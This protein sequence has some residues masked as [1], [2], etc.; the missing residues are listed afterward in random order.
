ME[1]R[2]YIFDTTLRD[3]EQ[4]LKVCLD[5]DA[6]LR[7]ARALERLGVDYIEAGFPVSSPGD[8]RAVEAIA[9]EIRGSRICALARA[10]QADI[11]AAGESLA[12]AEASR[13]HTFIAT[14]PIHREKKLRKDLKETLAMAV[15]AVRYARQ[16]TDDVEFSCEDAGRTPID[17]LCQFVEQTIAAGASVINIPD[18]VGY[19]LP[20]EFGAII[21]SL[22]NRVPNIDQAILSVH[23][24]ND[25]GL[26]VANTIS[27]IQNGARQ[28]EVTVNGIGERAGN[29]ALEELACI[30]STRA[31]LLPVS[32]G[33]KLKEIYH[34]SKVVRQTCN[35]PVQA[36]KAIV[37]DNAFSHSS[38]IH[39]DGLLK[40][41]Q[42]YEIISPES[43]GIPTHRLHLTARSGRHV[44]KHR[45]E[46]LGYREGSDYQLDE[47]YQRFLGL[48]DRKGAVYDYDLEA[49]V[50]APKSMT[51]VWYELEHLN[52]I[53]SS[54]GIASATVQLSHKNE[55]AIAAAVG[56]GPI[57]AVFR[58]IDQISGLQVRIKDYRISAEGEGRDALGSVHFVGSCQ[59]RNFYG[60]AA[61][62]DIVEAS[63]Q[64]YL[65]VVNA[66]LRTQ[67]MSGKD[68]SVGRSGHAFVERQGEESGWK[69]YVVELPERSKTL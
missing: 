45:L 39:Q 43:V 67:Q 55:S 20:D 68:R 40:E 22:R 35:S 19:T 7:I 47:I 4:S 32:C 18:T 60:Q 56:N 50:L 62:T 41:R 38:G 9:K 53:S 34:A 29:C 58:A 5:V 64:A 69:P 57:E 27:A 42:T 12:L 3:G 14:S 33:I 6:K 10:V 23:C 8:F 24:H 2:V 63:A 30:L 25:L 66:I 28:V 31:D 49:L 13:I 44:I 59:E 37:G 48:A 11:T 15:E 52:V 1:D 36:N 46:Q 17:E 61:S 54:N 16:W 26:A 65:S 21:A 51:E